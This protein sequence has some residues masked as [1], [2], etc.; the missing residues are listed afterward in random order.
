MSK[1]MVDVERIKLERANGRAAIRPCV[2]VS[3]GDGLN[4]LGRV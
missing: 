3:M 2:S 4:G 1:A